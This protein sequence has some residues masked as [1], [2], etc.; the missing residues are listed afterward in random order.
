MPEAVPLV[1]AC[2]ADD[3][4]KII[5]QVRADGSMYVYYIHMYMSHT[6]PSPTQA[7]TY[8]HHIHTYQSGAAR[9]VDVVVVTKNTL[10]HPYTPPP[11]NTY[12]HKH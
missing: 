11:Q 9:A 12:T 5:A 2:A 3:W 10:L 8:Q 4:Y 7:S 6:L 1:T